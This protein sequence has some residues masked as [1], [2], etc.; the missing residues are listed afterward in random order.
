[1]HQHAEHGEQECGGEE[2]RRAEDA[3]LGAQG[4]DQRKRRAADGELGDEE[5][6]CGD[7]AEPFAAV[8]DAEREEQRQPD[9]GVDV[10]LQARGPLDHRQVAAGVLQHHRLVNHRQ[11]EVGGRIVDRNARVLGERHHG[12]RDAGERHAGVDDELAVREGL[13]DGRERGRIRDERRGE[14]HHEQR[15]LG[16]KADHH[17]APRTEAAEG[18]ADVHRSERDEKAG[19][20]EQ[21]DQGDGVR[22]ADQRELCAERGDDRG[23]AGQAAEDEVGR[24][25]EQGAR[26]MSEHDLLLEQL[27]EHAVGLQHPRAAAVLQPGAALVDPAHEERRE[28]HRKHQFGQLGGECGEVAHRVKVSSTSSVTK[29]NSRYTEI[30]PRCSTV[31]NPVMRSTSAATGR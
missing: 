17:L 21:A 20:R 8:R 18:G 24:G 25:A 14:Q 23:G 19:E 6:Q 26:A 22:R 30:R 5:Q 12:E 15:G 3:H 2:F 16:E 29:L 28:Q 13:H 11:L 4:L 10:Q 27:G 1:M 7:D 31:T 9:A